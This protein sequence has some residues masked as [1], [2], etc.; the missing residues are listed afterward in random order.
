MR[1]A[2]RPS[3]ALTVID[4]DRD[5]GT[6][7]TF[8]IAGGKTTDADG[9]RSATPSGIGALT[10]QYGTDGNNTN[11]SFSLRTTVHVDLSIL[12]YRHQESRSW[13]P[14][15]DQGISARGRFKTKLEVT[16]VTDESTAHFTPELSLLLLHQRHLVTFDTDQSKF[17]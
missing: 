12:P 1:A 3:T 11:A 8:H 14:L 4:N 2:I 10:A 15:R 17:I 16:C 6:D 7:Q 13:N 9:K 5:A